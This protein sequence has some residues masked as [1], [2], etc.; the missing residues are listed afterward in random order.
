MV[1]YQNITMDQV[2]GLWEFLNTL[3]A[4][5]DCMMYEPGERAE[6]TSLA[7]LREEI[8][9]HVIDGDD[10]LCIAV[11]TGKIVGFLQAE[12][13]KFNRVRHTAYVVVGILAEHRGKGIGTALF[14]RLEQW[15]QE[16]RVARLE[17]TVECPN[18]AAK[19][20]YEKCGFVVEGIR[21]KSMVVDGRYVDEYAMAKLL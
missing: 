21:K 8:Q 16:N 18:A 12:R 10:Y 19:R 1:C 4:E 2:E 7:A 6:R 15:A 11:E 14:A 17:L 13:G 3:D 20:L 5:T 9:N